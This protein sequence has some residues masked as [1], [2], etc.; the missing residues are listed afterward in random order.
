M[1]SPKNTDKSG[2]AS[3]AWAPLEEAVEILKGRCESISGDPSEEFEDAEGEGAV[4]DTGGNESARD[5]LDHGKKGAPQE[6]LKDKHPKMD[7]SGRSPLLSKENLPNRSNSEK[8][9]METDTNKSTSFG[10]VHD[11]NVVVPPAIRRS[12]RRR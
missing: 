10:T 5:T 11:D 12:V 1:I 2:D 7:S 8:H 6:G 3:E 4:V 9:D